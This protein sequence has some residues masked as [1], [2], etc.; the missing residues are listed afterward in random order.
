MPTDAASK[1]RNTQFLLPVFIALA[2]VYFIVL[3]KGA[4]FPFVLSAALAYILSPVIKYFEVR[5]IRRSYA[6]AGLYL[7]VGVVLFV[8]VYLL[9]HFLSFELESLQQSWPEYAGR[10]QQF[11]LNLNTKLVDKYPF[12]ASCTSRLNWTVCWK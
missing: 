4:L 9:F 3:A 11:V 2:I 12:M 1:K 8:V 10:M 5:G 6:V 7:S